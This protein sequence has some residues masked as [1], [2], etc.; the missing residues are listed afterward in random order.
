MG[1]ATSRK[2]LAFL[3]SLLAAIGIF[4]PMQAL[5]SGLQVSP[6]RV[7]LAEGQ[8]SEKLVLKNTSSYEV[9]LEARTYLWTQ[10]GGED[11]LLPTPD[12]A[13]SGEIFF[14]KPGQ[15]QVILLGLL[16]QP[17]PGGG[18][19]SYR[20]VLRSDPTPGGAPRTGAKVSL[21]ISIP[22]FVAPRKNGTPRISVDVRKGE[23]TKVL[24]FLKNEG[25][26]YIRLQKLHFLEADGTPHLETSLNSYLLP[27]KG[28]LVVVSKTDIPK[29]GSVA[30][31]YIWGGAPELLQSR[32]IT[33]APPGEKKNKISSHV[34][35]PPSP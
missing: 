35:A 8:V 14:L 29:S 34:S 17:E 33:L 32:E 16:K 20:M 1:Q 28:N 10:E 19:K 5:S 21:S 22:I 30:L 25:L 4:F 18:E 3:W 15:S 11:R 23:G 13:L 26:R 27:G 9:I 6:V 31:E 12:I 24:L 7:E 2:Y